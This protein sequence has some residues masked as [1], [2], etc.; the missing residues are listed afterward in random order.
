MK[1]LLSVVF[2]LSLAV[3]TTACGNYKAVSSSSSAPVS[4]SQPASSSEASAASSSGSETIASGPVIEMKLAHYAAVDHPGGIAA[5]MFAD[6]IAK[7]TNGA[8][9]ISVYPNNE[10]G[11]PD[12]MLEQNILGA[13]DMTLGTQGSLDKYSKKFATVMLPF[14]F[15]NYQHAYDVLD[16]PFYD[17]TVNDLDEQGLVFVGSWD[18]GFRNLTNSKHPVNSPADVSGLKI[19]TP[20]EIQLQSCM[21]ALGANVQKIA[22][23]ELYLS[24]KQGVV[25]GQE[26]PLAV[27]YYNK[28]YEAQ[29]YLAIT[30]H[31][32]NSMNLVISKKTW[33]KLTPEQQTIIREESKNAADYMRG[34]IQSSEENYIKLLEEQGMEVTYPDR[35]QFAALMEPSYKAISEYC[36]NQEYIDT[37]LKMVDDCRKK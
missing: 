36:G 14:V 18:Y 11:A 24:L 6:N 12:E 37:F 5:Q 25:D 2:A 31:V 28:Y 20:G 15:D 19:R 32:Y 16:G 9:H 8:I 34:A 33:E 26:N 10:L 29:K 17:W 7:R 1:K 13:V 27:I 4:S 23:N 3:S 35:A 22:F 21:E 30:N